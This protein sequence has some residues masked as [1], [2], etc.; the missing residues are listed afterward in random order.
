MTGPQG[1]ATPARP[2][3]CLTLA[4]AATLGACAPPADDL[5][6]WMQQQR[7][8]AQPAVGALPDYP[9]FVPLDYGARNRFDPFDPRRSAPP[10]PAAAGR[11]GGALPAAL[12]RE[13]ARPRGPLELRPLEQITLVGT[14]AGAAGVQALV[15]IDGRLYPVRVGD[16]LGPDRGRVVRIDER[17]I[18]L[19]ELVQDASGAWAER[20]TML[21]IQEASR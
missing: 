16:R 19:R 4:L 17:R 14:L 10:D 13:L 12:A 11:A 15:R 18:E 2:W 7:S 1:L 21:K 8:A 3:Q 20:T 5:D 6:A 9:A